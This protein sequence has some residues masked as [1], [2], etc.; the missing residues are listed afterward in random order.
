[1][2][3]PYHIHSSHGQLCGILKNDFPTWV[4]AAT[5]S[6]FRNPEGL[7]A[8]GRGRCGLWILLEPAHPFASL[9][10]AISDK[11][12]LWCNICNMQYHVVCNMLKIMIRGGA[13]FIFSVTLRIIMG[14]VGFIAHI[15]VIGV[16][17]VHFH[18]FYG[19]QYLGKCCKWAWGRSFKS[20]KQQI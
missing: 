11:F 8:P 17:G 18:R 4:V 1:M 10:R 6:G 3:L 9:F 14:R 19:P 7:P 5:R 12:P 13:K 16:W 2:C 20:K 15:R